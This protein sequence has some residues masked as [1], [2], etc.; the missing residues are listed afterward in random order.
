MPQENDTTFAFPKRRLKV[1]LYLK[2]KTSA[3]TQC[4]RPPIEKETHPWQ[5][6][7]RPKV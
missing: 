6:F 2:K 1:F 3:K 5:T 7:S 4:H